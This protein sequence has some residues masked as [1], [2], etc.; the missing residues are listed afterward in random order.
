MLIILCLVYYYN[1]LAGYL[2]LIFNC[3]TFTGCLFNTDSTGDFV[4]I[5]INCVKF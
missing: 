4:W 1:L 5:T 2:I 3:K